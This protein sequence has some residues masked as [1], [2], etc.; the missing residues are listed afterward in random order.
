M[1]VKVC[2]L[3]TMYFYTT[4]PPVWS[5]ILSTPQ[6]FWCVVFYSESKAVKGPNWIGL[7]I[8]VRGFISSPLSHSNL[9]LGLPQT[10]SFSIRAQPAVSGSR[11]TK[12]GIRTRSRNGEAGFFVSNH[13][14]SYGEI[15]SGM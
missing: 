12:A 11:N 14:T 5:I 9:A 13:R 6:R 3:C 2:L 1:G 8:W 15:S 4:F 7:G 10:A